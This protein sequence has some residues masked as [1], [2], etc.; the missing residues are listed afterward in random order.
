MKSRLKHFLSIV[1]I[2]KSDQIIAIKVIAGSGFEQKK[3]S[4]PILES[5]N[6]NQT[7][8]KIEQ[9]FDVLIL[10]LFE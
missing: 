2:K 7:R 5:D 4:D 10:K 8:F 9:N 1:A 6:Y 3:M